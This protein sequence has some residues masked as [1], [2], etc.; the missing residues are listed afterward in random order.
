MTLLLAVLGFAGWQL[1][2]GNQRQAQLVDTVSTLR[3]EQ[4][5]LRQTLSDVQVVT[6]GTPGD[7]LSQRL[8]GDLQ[9]VSGMRTAVAE[10]Y[11][12]M[13]KLPA[14]QA[15]LGLPAPER[16]RGK[17]LKS[18]TVLA[19]GSIDLVFDAASG[20]EGGRIRLIADLSHADAMG[21]QWRC[22]TADYPQIKR[23][24]S[25]CDYVAPTAGKSQLAAPPVS[26]ES[27]LAPVGH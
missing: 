27:S 5:E 8:A 10:Y 20:V 21:I 2:V 23:A 18:A 16:Y 3:K 7:A 6:L 9:A 25:T 13:G 24:I 15:E 4:Q 11:Q 17:S 1:H 22:E 14:N 26:G 19:D 12:A